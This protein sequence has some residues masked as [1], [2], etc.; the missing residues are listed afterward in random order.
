MT[1]IPQHRMAS[2]W[3]VGRGGRSAVDV[4]SHFGAVQ[5]QDYAAAK[6]S[7]GVRI[8]G[9]TDD[10]VELAFADGAFLRTHILRPTW[11]FVAPT[12]LRWMQTLTAPRVHGLNKGMYRKLEL[13]AKLFW[14]ADDVIGRVLQ[15]GQHLTRPELGTALWKQRRIKA[16]GQRL[17][18]ILM[19]AE[20]EAL[21]CSG[22]RRG[23]QHTYALVEERA[24]V[25][26]ALDRDE[27]LARLAVRY[28]AGHGPAR[29]H[30]LAWWSG[31]TV[32]DARAA[33]ALASAQL[34]TLEVDGQASWFV[35]AEAPPAPRTPIAFLL[36]IYD[37]YTLAYKDRSD[38]CDPD[39]GSRLA[40][41]GNALTSVVVID[42]KVA[43][44][45]KRTLTSSTV[46]VA[47]DLFRTPTAAEGQALDGAV[48]RYGTFLGRAASRS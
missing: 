27:A 21:I 5:A 4:V 26:D 38:I 7:L 35:A 47:C 1:T 19:H 36:S 37:E 13:D 48:D 28:F 6:W 29:E 9:A 17:A 10:D 34:E 46:D 11:H 2:Q 40:A 33:I 42:G 16:D 18:Y 45:W 23:K 15:G 44:T 30:D 24:P 32:K 31:L 20:L 39:D 8:D 14:R 43:G 25:G 3:L 41:M 22:P 12:D